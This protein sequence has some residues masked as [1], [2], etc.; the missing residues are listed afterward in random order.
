MVLL[1]IFVQPFKNVKIILS[2]RAIQKP[3]AQ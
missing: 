1:L 2:L 3:A